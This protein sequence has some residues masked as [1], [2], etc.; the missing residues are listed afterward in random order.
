[1]FPKVGGSNDSPGILHGVILTLKSYFCPAILPMCVMQR[2]WYIIT[3]N[4]P[5]C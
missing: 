3:L 1:M 4:L 5:Y 2:F